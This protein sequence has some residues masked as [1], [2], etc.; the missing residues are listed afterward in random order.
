MT[1]H[2]PEEE[3]IFIVLGG[4]V[5]RGCNL[6]PANMLQRKNVEERSSTLSIDNAHVFFFIHPLP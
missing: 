4:E 2:G 3:I 6:C 1:K 5:E